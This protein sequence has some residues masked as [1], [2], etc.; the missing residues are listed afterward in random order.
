MNL[1]EETS[2]K[3]NAFLV[4]G[5]TKHL[6]GFSNVKTSNVKTPCNITFSLSL[7]YN[8]HVAPAIT[9]NVLNS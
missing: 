8:K 7:M 3:C 4:G 2:C 5:F 6:V 9:L 1:E